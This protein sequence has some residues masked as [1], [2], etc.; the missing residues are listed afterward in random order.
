[1]YNFTPVNS[2]IG[3]FII[4]FSIVLYFYTTGR[5]AGISGILSNTVTNKLNRPSNFLFILG[6]FTGPLIYCFSINL[7]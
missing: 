2:L 5:L 7:Q 3:G 6:L 4:G 1:M